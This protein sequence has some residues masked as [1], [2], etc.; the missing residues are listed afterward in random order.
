[1]R[2][3]SFK[4]QAWCDGPGSTSSAGA[5][6]NLDD[7]RARSITLAVSTGGGCL[8]IFTLSLS[9]SLSLSLCVSLGDGSI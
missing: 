8:E 7:S 1:M 5:S 3:L 2:A 9:L 4:F 6:Y